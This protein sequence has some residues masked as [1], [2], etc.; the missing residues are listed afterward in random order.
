M[1]NATESA[2][3]TLRRYARAIS[4]LQSAHAPVTLYESAD[5]C[6]HPEP[7]EPE[8]MEGADDAWAKYDQWHE[9]HPWG[10]D[11][12]A[13]AARICHLTPRHSSCR[14]C[15]ELV[16][17]HRGDDDY[18]VDAG[19]CIVLPVIGKALSEEITDEH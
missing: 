15:T 19:D 2:E 5:G 10:E 3:V 18:F 11:A 1:T 6:G 17:G 8:Q 7:D 13:E 16:Y 9:D 14:A 12:A 4:A